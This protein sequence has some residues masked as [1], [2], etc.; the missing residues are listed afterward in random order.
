MEVLVVDPAKVDI[1]CQ[2]RTPKSVTKIRSFLG[3]TVYYRRFVKNFSKLASPLSRLTQKEVKNQWTSKCEASFQEL[4]NR[5]T[6]API[7]ALSNKSSE[8]VVYSDASKH[9]L[10]AVLMQ[11]GK[12][13]ML[14]GNS[15][16]MKGTIW[17]IT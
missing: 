1:V 14:L 2:S 3:L 6:S 9:G 8:Y 17:L 13:P 16:S 4:K 12:V 15:R 7:L 11:N 10:D 5:L